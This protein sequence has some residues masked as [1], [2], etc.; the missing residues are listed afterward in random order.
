[1]KRDKYVLVIDLSAKQVNWGPTLLK[2]G[3]GSINKAKEFIR[4]L[5]FN[6]EIGTN[7]SIY[8][9]T[10]GR[11]DSKLGYYIYWAR[12][13]DGVTW[14]REMRGD[15]KYFDP[16]QIRD[17]KN[18]KDIEDFKVKNTE[19]PVVTEEQVILKIGNKFAYFE[20]ALN[21][22]AK[23]MLARDKDLS[24]FGYLLEVF[25]DQGELFKEFFCFVESD[26]WK[27]EDL[28]K[29]EAIELMA[30]FGRARGFFESLETARLVASA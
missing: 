2:A 24:V 25:K 17:V 4:T 3:F 10:I 14:T 1:M 23:V 12:T 29:R 15:K 19:V 6:F 11:W 5:N 13:S 9:V 26:L 27:K 21:D 20:D 22:T 16:E 28:T 30:D 7:N 8:C 18:W